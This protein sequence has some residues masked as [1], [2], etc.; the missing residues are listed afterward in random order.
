MSTLTLRLES[1][2]K[3][4]RAVIAAAQALADERRHVEVEPLH[5]VLPRRTDGGSGVDRAFIGERRGR[6]VGH[7]GIRQNL[8]AFEQ[9]RVQQVAGRG[10]FARLADN[11]PE[12][13]I[14][15]DGRVMGTYI[16]GLFADDRQR[17][18]WLE[19][20]AAGGAAIA[21]DALVEETLDK[22]A[23]HLAAH[24]AIDRLLTLAR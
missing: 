9:Q 13:A 20:F 24:V 21:Y 16:H 18:A 22:L 6:H 3:D 23:A 7:Q 17:S 4:A 19:R 12:G 11:T 8:P 1:Y 14:S 10:P 15:A 2:E 5:L